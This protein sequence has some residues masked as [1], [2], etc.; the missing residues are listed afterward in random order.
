M[1]GWNTIQRIRRLEEQATGLGLKF[2]NYKHDDMHGEHLA[3]V[4]KDQGALPVYSRDAILFAGTLEAAA[5]WMQGVEWARNYD[6][7]TI[8]KNMD[9]QRE[10]KEQDERGRQLMRTLKEGKLVTGDKND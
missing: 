7:M 2:T 5:Y 6:R 4:P 10:R 8:N 9:K 3:L 1:S